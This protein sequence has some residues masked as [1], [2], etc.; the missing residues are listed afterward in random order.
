MTDNSFVTG[1]FRIISKQTKTLSIYLK[2]KLSL[3][4]NKYHSMTFLTSALDGGEW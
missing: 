2:A 4:L 3:C 1:L